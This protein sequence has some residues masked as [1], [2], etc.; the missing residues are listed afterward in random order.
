VKL[1]NNDDDDDEVPAAAAAAEEE[2]GAAEVA[3]AAWLLL[4]LCLQR[5]AED[6][7]ERRVV[8]DVIRFTTAV[9][10]VAEATEE[11]AANCICFTT[12]PL[13]RLATIAP[14]ALATQRCM[15]VLVRV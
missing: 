2:L 14:A 4:L 12:L 6:V 7:I 8:A 3:A 11:F 9:A 15:L 10:P 13:A 1:A 5:R